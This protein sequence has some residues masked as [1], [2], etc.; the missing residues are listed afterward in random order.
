MDPA[1][2]NKELS[3]ELTGLNKGEKELRKKHILIGISVAAL[4]IFM[5]IIVLI[6]VN[7][8]SKE[9][10]GSND[11]SEKTIVG[12]INC[13]YEIESTNQNTKLIGNEYLKKSEF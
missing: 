4:S 12:E 10:N 5:L 9:E 1:M 11:S 13:V 2:A 8:T 6:T 3:S 7:L